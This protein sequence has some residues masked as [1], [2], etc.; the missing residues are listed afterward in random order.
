MYIDIGADS[1][2]SAT[3]SFSFSGTSTSRT[4]DIKISQLECSNYN[5]PPSTCLQY[6]TTITGRIETFN[7][8]VSND[9]HINSHE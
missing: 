2:D 5:A 6:H 7:Y 1:G 8:A 4:W 3:L 9:N